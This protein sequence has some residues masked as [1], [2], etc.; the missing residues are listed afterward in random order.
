MIISSPN[1]VSMLEHPDANL[2]VGGLN[3]SFCIIQWCSLV[4]ILGVLAG[5]VD[6]Q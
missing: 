4:V 1:I 6:Q 2:M 5:I 3:C